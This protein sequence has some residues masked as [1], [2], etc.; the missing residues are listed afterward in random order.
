MPSAKAQRFTDRNVLGKSN[1]NSKIIGIKVYLDKL[2]NL[3]AGIQITY[4][5]NKKGGDYVKKDKDNK[6]KQYTEEDYLSKGGNYVRS[7]YGT[8]SVDNRLQSL[9]FAFSDGSNQKFGNAKTV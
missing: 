5:G 1:L 4:I 8:L 6:E 2:S 3:I 7:I 9:K